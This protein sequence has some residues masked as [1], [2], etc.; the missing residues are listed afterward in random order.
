M[1]ALDVLDALDAVQGSRHPAAM[2]LQ[3]IGRANG[4]QAGR[5]EAFP[6][7]EGTQR[8]S[9]SHEAAIRRVARSIAD[10]S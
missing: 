1:E 9:L 5:E 3:A 4:V 6:E 10:H 8:V 7:S 2:E